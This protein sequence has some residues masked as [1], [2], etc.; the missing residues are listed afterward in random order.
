MR[1]AA[2]RCCYICLYRSVETPP[3]ERSKALPVTGRGGACAG[4]ASKFARY[5]QMVRLSAL[6]AGHAVLTLSPPQ[7]LNA[8]GLIRLQSSGGQTGSGSGSGATGDTGL[9]RSDGSQTQMLE[10]PVVEGLA[11]RPVGELS[12][13]PL[14]CVQV[15]GVYPDIAVYNRQGGPVRWNGYT[16]QMWPDV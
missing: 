11:G 3:V 1:V 16:R 14:F 10:R 9:P 5:L 2:F 15:P 6:R 13:L 12:R 8:A 4:E 7:V